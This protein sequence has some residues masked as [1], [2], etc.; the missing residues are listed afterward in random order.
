MS[1]VSHELLPSSVAVA[2]ANNRVPKLIGRVTDTACVLSL[3]ETDRIN[4]MLSAYESETAHQLAVL[5]VPTLDGDSIESFSLRVA[6]D[7][8]LG[9][10]GANNG[11]FIIIAMR[12]RAARIEL[13]EG[14]EAHI[15]AAKA[16][17]IMKESMIPEFAKGAIGKG[18]EAGIIQLKE[19]ARKMVVSSGT[20]PEQL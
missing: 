13:G 17:E 8:K 16:T 6:N 2:A 15:P 9:R 5:T 3:I 10:E 20:M 1:H 12:E 14:F 4:Q 19:E 7:W 11:I 18:L